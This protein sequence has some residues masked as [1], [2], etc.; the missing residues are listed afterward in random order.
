MANKKTIAMGL[1][2]L[3]EL[4]PNWNIT[5]NTINVWE[6][7]LRDLSDAEVEAGFELFISHS[8]SE[9]ARVPRPGDIRAALESVTQATWYEAWDEIMRLAPLY[10]Y[11]LYSG[12]KHITPEFSSEI[13][14]TA[15]ER[16][17]GPQY[18]AS[19]ENKDLNTARAQFRVMYES[20]IR[21]H[22]IASAY[23]SLKTNPKIGQI[24][25]KLGKRMV[26]CGN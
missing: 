13:V 20:I 5:E 16:M 7:A 18:F 12:G 26:I 2:M 14:K 10:I 6:L 9:F 25:A 17:G 15:M 23:P 22:L 3:R 8:T 1:T 21:S 24:V 11:P 4:F 19:I